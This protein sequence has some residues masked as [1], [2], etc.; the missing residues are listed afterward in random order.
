MTSGAAHQ[1]RT[2]LNTHLVD[3][4]EESQRYWLSVAA[5]LALVPTSQAQYGFPLISQDATLYAVR[6][7]DG[8]KSVSTPACLGKKPYPAF[9]A[10]W[11][12]L[13]TI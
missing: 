11:L 4:Q 2:T 12:E 9:S 10:P 3:Q 1:I 8:Q 13:S 6:Q 7:G 5:A